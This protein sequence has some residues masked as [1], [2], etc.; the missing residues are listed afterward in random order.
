[1]L[2]GIKGGGFS[3]PDMIKRLIINSLIPLIAGKA[4]ISASPFAEKWAA[5]FSK[6]LTYISSLV[7]IFQPWVTISRSTK[8]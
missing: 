2:V 3:V 7:I 8:K 6:L 5:Y 4:L 1:V